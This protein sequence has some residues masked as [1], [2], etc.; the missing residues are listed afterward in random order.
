M[1][2]VLRSVWRTIP[3]TAR[4]RLVDG[5]DQSQ[6]KFHEYIDEIYD[7]RLGIKTGW[8]Q[9]F[10][11]EE[12]AQTTGG[13]PSMIKSTSYL[14]LKALLRKLRPTASDRLVDIGCGSGRVPIYF[15]TS[16]IGHSMGLDFHQRAI[17][18]A[19][20]NLATAR[21]DRSKVSFVQQDATTADY[22]GFTLIF[23]AN[24]FGDT[25]MKRVLEKLYE[26]RSRCPRRMQVCYYNPVCGALFAATPWLK[27]TGQ[28][29][30]LKK[31]LNIYEAI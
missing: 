8:L 7:R 17:D 14:I 18:A 1:K 24:P 12:R 26:S 2:Q 3:Q 27:Q 13:D 9:N 5:Y 21:I 25:T 15:A 19:K 16:P 6:V 11:N 30:T 10:S 22:D 31:P 20:A 23:M 28:I 29:R 4:T